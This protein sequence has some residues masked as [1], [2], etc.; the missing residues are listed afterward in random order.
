VALVRI[1]AVIVTR[2]D[3]VIDQIIEGPWPE[4]F[5]EVVVWDNSVEADLKVYGR[6]AAIAKASHPVIYVQDDDCILPL[7]SLQ[8]LVDAYEPG[9][10]VANMPRS[11]W[12][13]YSDSTL[14]GWGAI[15][16][17]HLPREAFGRLPLFASEAERDWFH[18]T[19]DVAFSAL[20]RRTV[21]DV[22]FAHL[23]WAEGPDRMFT[24]RPTHAEERERMLELCRE[25]RGEDDDRRDW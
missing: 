17:R 21:I 9:R 10:L 8:A 4:A 19:C 13:G 18:I 12:N 3:C 1:S 5:H 16:D 20:T 14:V 25:I 15:F 2:G 24:S 6:Y 7:G 22:P 23:P 11:R